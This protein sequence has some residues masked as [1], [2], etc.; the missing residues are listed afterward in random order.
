MV[1]FLPVELVDGHA[2]QAPRVMKAFAA[3][4]PPSSG[5]ARHLLPEGE[6]HQEVV[7][8]RLPR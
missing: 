7:A 2:A 1:F 8:A 6:G 3:G 5:A 4:P